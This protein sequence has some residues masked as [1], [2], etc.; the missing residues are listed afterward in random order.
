MAACNTSVMD[1]KELGKRVSRGFDILNE[2]QACGDIGEQ[3]DR[4]FA[5]WENLLREYEAELNR[6]GV[7]A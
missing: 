1:R 5:A 4:Y 3:Y 2:M 7:A 6:L